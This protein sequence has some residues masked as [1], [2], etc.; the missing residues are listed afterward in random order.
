MNPPGKD[1]PICQK[2]KLWEGCITPFMQPSSGMDATRIIIIG[3]APGEQEDKKGVPFVGQSGQLLR[4]ALEA[5]GIADEV[6]FTNV[7][8][9]RPPDN[10]ITKQAINYCKEF[11]ILEIAQQTIGLNTTLEQVWLMGNSPLNGIL[12]ESG[13]SSW[14]G[15]VVMRDGLK[16][17]PLY[18]P[19]YILRDMSRFDD[20]VD[21]MDLALSGETAE[22]GDDWEI[23][24]PRTLGEVQLMVKDLISFDQISFDT[25]TSTLDPFAPEA[26]LL[27]VSFARPGR[28]Y[29]VV[30]EH[31][32][33]WWGT[34]VQ[35]KRSSSELQDV[36][37]QIASVLEIMN[38]HIIG[39]NVKFDQ[40]MERAL[41]G[42]DWSA[43]GDTMII[44]HLL[45]SRQGIHGLKHLAGLHLGMYE[46]EQELSDYIKAHKDAN[47][48]FGGSY[49]NIPL[50]VLLP[51]G[52][53][54]AKATLLLHEKLYPELSKKQKKHYRALVEASNALAHM[55]FNGIKIDQ[56]IADRYV[57]A[58]STMQQRYFD[59]IMADPKVKKLMKDKND[60]GR[61]KEFIFNPNSSQ[62]L[63]ELYFQYYKIPSQGKTETGSD[64]TS[65]KLMK[66][67]E[68]EYPIVGK[69]RS[70]KLLT[71]ML[72]TYL[73]PAC[74]KWLSGDGRVRCTYNMH[75]TVT[76]RLSSSEPNLQNIPTP[77]KEPGTILEHLPIKNIF[78]HSFKGGC[79]LAL[80]YSGMEL[81]V[82]ASLANCGGMIDIHKSG[83]DFHSMVAIMSLEG[84]TFSEIDPDYV[85]WFK[86]NK[87]E[88][89][90]M[91][92]WTSW[93][94][95][96]GG[97]AHTLENLY[98]IDYDRARDTV[99]V[100]FDVFPE[101]PAF[102]KKCIDF[103]VD[104]GYIESPF[105]RR[106]HLPYIN[107]RRDRGRANAD[108]RA[109]MNM[110]VQSTASDTLTLSLAVLDK[111]L[112]K[113]EYKSL[114]VNTVHDSV[115]LDVYPG[116]LHDLAALSKDVMENIVEYGKTY[117]PQIDFSWLLCPLKADRD[118][119]TH[120]GSMHEYEPPK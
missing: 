6:M 33:T 39:H 34:E 117:M 76:G 37:D 120:Y 13:I 40:N 97:D 106:E 24:I 77:E 98:G 38:G 15:N 74:T 54:D 45:D 1:N 50:E 46:Y 75:G 95:L 92:K 57:R 101:V 28:A 41:L 32:Q 78:T 93:T 111:E 4:D 82:F 91:Y 102:Q 72:G 25:E 11:A 107:D 68:A 103:A 35:K 9:C 85:K 19:A 27:S 100:Y 108:R 52:A 66:P 5:L 81:R 73:E 90:Y 2:C 113:H 115:L 70:F 99:G 84:K 53:L 59:L 29:S 86:K 87:N 48:R 31:P 55:Q 116:E 17:V 88:I 16:F 96:Y 61:R 114:M 21:A 65:A 58:Y 94:I 71:K 105:G 14:H 110:P 22:K 8:R 49:A 43:G 67:L 119:G 112:S 89:R 79:L 12:G 18:H 83:L 51:Y 69:I 10:K 36:A 30:L 42:V 26:V 47:P 60:D 63:A 3:E 56:Y 44:S 118:T 104:N 7:V 109:A 20:W 64:S 23:I 62:Q 80:D